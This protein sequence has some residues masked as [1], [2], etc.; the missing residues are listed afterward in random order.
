M[1]LASVIWQKKISWFINRYNITLVYN[2]L[3]WEFNYGDSIINYIYCVFLSKKNDSIIY[4]RNIN[5]TLKYLLH[6]IINLFIII[7]QKLYKLKYVSENFKNKVFITII[8]GNTI[9][10]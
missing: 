10:L 7:E 5:V 4:T 1:I 8:Y 6:Y 2:L 3:F 9:I